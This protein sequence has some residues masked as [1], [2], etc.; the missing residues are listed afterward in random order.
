MLSV[1]A[2]LLDRTVTV[3]PVCTGPFQR[4]PDAPSMKKG[5][6]HCADRTS[7]FLQAAA[8]LRLCVP[9]TNDPDPGAECRRVGTARGLQKLADT[10]GGGILG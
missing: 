4:I 8:A 3:T 6:I 7:L 1:W 2:E 10:E 5:A 9:L